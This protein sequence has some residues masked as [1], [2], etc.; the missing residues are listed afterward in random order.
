MTTPAIILGLLFLPGLVGLILCHLRNAP[1]DF[2][3]WAF[4]GLG[5]SFLFFALGHFARTTAMVAMLPPW[6]P[7][8]ELLIY[9]TGVLEVVIG[10]A[11]FSRRYGHL[12]AS[13]ALV[14]LVTFFPA[15][16]YAAWNQVGM[17]GHEWGPVYLLI[18]APLQ[19]LL[20]AWADFCRRSPRATPLT[21]HQRG[22]EPEVD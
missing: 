8:R 3:R 9:A 13:A 20:I 14:V 19:M 16:I 22:F 4:T 12:A 6:V 7:A 18:R 21:F 11:L 5:L 2:P 17:G 1:P 10:L 15:N